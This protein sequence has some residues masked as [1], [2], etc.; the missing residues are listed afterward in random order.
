V[1]KSTL[2][3]AAVLGILEETHMNKTQYSWLGAL[4]FL[5]YFAFQLPNNYLLQRIPIGRYLGILLILWGIITALTALAQD[6]TQLAVCR[7]LLGLFEGGT[8]PAILLIF[9]TMYRRCEQS[10]ALGFVFLSNA[11]GSVVGTAASV[12]IA[13]MDNSHGISTWKWQ[14]CLTV[15]S[16][17]VSMG[18][19]AF[20]MLVDGPNFWLLRITKDEKAIMRERTNDN[21]VVR[22]SK[23]EYHQYWE[24][25]KEARFWLIC[26]TVL[27]DNLQNGGLI[28]YSTVLVHG[29]GFDSITS[30]LLQV[31]NGVFTVIYIAIAV[32]IHRRTHQLIFT[33]CGLSAISMVGCLLLATLPNTAIKLI[34]YYLTWAQVGSYVLTLTILTSTVSGYSK[35]IFYNSAVMIFYTIGN[36][37]GPLMIVD[38]QAPSYYGAM[39]GYLGCNVTA[40]LCLLSVRCWLSNLNKSRMD[41]KSNTPTDVYLNLT[42]REDRN[43]MYNL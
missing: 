18:F 25:L 6:F 39:W 43:F 20:F 35:K 37:A 30:I 15:Y 21:A 3:V 8:Y 23:I 28:L 36:F 13:K 14:A 11:V 4:F 1:D 2:S 31:P 38:S 41:Q 29:L 24:A 27:C 34:G 32:F 16:I 33:A 12:G 22:R 26:L 5:G 10:A 9:N 19:I 17:T 42:D 40:M 7:T